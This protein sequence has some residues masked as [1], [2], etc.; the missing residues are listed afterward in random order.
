MLVSYLKESDTSVSPTMRRMTRY[1]YNNAVKVLLQLR[2]DIIRYPRK[3]F[4][5]RTT[6][7]DQPRMVLGYPCWKPNSGEEPG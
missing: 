4:E 5:A 2:G 7:S 1:E 3:R 6:A